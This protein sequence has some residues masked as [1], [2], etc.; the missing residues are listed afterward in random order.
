MQRQTKQEKQEK[1][2]PEQQSRG[3]QRQENPENVCP[4][5][6]AKADKNRKITRMSA[7]SIMQWRTD[8]RFIRKCPP[9]QHKTDHAGGL[10][11]EGI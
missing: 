9:H 7:L 4:T 8:C 11:E 3:R 6:K 2:L 5:S 1:C 10:Y